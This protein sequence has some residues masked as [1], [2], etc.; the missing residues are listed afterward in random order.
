MKYNIN[1]G[2][3]RDFDV[4]HINALPPRAYFI[5]F[6][7][8]RK[9]AETDFRNERKSS[10]KVRLLSGEWDFRF[11]KD[12]AKMPARLDTE[13]G[14]FDKI[15]VPCMWQRTGYQ[16]PVYLNC[17]YEFKTF[18]P[19]LP[20]TMPSAIYRKLFNVDTLKKAY[21]LTFLG[22]AN[23]ADIFVN[24][25]FVGYR[26]GTHNT[27]EY[28][29]TKLIH[30]GEN[31]LV[32]V[33]HK[34]C[35]GSFL[36]AQDMFR[37]NGINRDVLLYEYEDA[38]IYD[39]K[40]VA[41]KTGRTYSLSADV[42]LCG[43]LS[44]KTLTVKIVRDGKAVTE[45]TTE[46][47][48]D[49]NIKFTK[50]TVDEW[51]AEIPAYYEIYFILRDTK[52]DID[53]ARQ[54][55][56]FRTIKIDGNVYLFNGKAIKMKGVNHHDT[57]LTKG[58]AMGIE[59]Y[60]LDV[61][62]M[63]EFNVNAVRTSHYPP[64]PIFHQL[65]TV[66]GLY[67][68]DEGDIETHGCDELYG[69]CGE[70]SMNPA[71]AN[72]YVDRIQRMYFRDRNNGCIAM[73]SL[74][75]ESHGYYC[76]DRCYEFIKSEN[77]D[78]P[79][80]YEGVIRTKRFAYD[81]ASEMY[82]SIPELKKLAMGEHRARHSFVD[83]KDLFATRPFFLCEYAHAMG[84]GPGN[85]KEYW[86]VIYDNDFMMGGC[87]W[88]WADHTVLHENDKYKYR[89]TYGG[90]HGEPQHDGHF[91]VDGLF[92]SDRRPHTGALE[93]K[94]VYRPVI[95]KFANGKLTFTNT[96]RFR[97]TEYI[98][99]CWEILQDGMVIDSG[100]FLKDIP[101][102]KSAT[103][104]APFVIKDKSADTF[105]NIRYYDDDFLIAMEQL[106]I[107]DV[108][109]YS[110]AVEP[111][112]YGISL[113]NAEGYYIVE[114]ADGYAVI[115]GKNGNLISYNCGGK[116][117]IS[118]STEQK[119][120]VP[121]FT[122]AFN[123][124]D[125]GFLYWKKDN[126]KLLDA[127]VEDGRLLNANMT[128]GVVTFN[129]IRRVTFG[130]KSIDMLISTAFD[131]FGK[132]AVTGKI[133]PDAMENVDVPRVGLNIALDRSLEN[134]K[135]YG[136]GRAENLPD[137]N[138]Q[139]PMGTYSAKVADMDEPYVF[140][141]DSG[142]HGDTRYLILTDDNGKGVKISGVKPFS[143]SVHHYTQDVLQKAQHR[144]DLT[145]MNGTFLS[146]DGFVRGIGSSSCGPDTLPEYKIVTNDDPLKFTFVFE[147]IG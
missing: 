54:L 66:Y 117:Y 113:T 8:E 116:A 88:E 40:L 47:N 48:A 83:G 68:M 105:L 1:T 2:H 135:Y 108:T 4:L 43:E 32:L 96:N 3:Y 71:W 64:D 79:V 91:C 76:Q 57:H 14:K 42:K 102:E 62:L 87:I 141:Q 41:E 15:T 74:G 122:R 93:M 89:Y 101:A 80:F 138:I 6:G 24:G 92:Y 81:V 52:G 109:E 37:E 28:D 133:Y 143:F 13:K 9:L 120:F 12:C 119:G 112:D 26:E 98:D 126:I 121:N 99:F 35:N 17:P 19:F 44:D 77:S 16:E 137:F 7:S 82:T 106:P 69:F 95:C 10:D 130:E 104:K 110:V 22:V 107:N 61:K 78:I 128:R 100:E 51:N 97:S 20:D 39:Y 134:A 140:P 84:V 139:A 118:D 147:P 111:S 85:L 29:I 45:L 131:A 27:T 33:M 65:A 21:I 60:E 127:Q 86:D 146:L 132:M 70:L 46:A 144:E 136:R 53:C 114:W 34:W 5:P 55:Y 38:Y 145:D 67:I 123:D 103:V 50:L 90:D 94:A 36:E 56:G 124:N 59:D 73:W 25:E 49:T 58:Y 18:A 63:K 72:R 142:N 30:A 31:E 23:N 125:N 129:A 75:N 115:A 11:Y